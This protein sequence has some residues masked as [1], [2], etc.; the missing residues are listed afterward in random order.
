MAFQP[1]ENVECIC[2]MKKLMAAI[3]ELESNLLD[4]TGCDL[5]QAML[6]C[7]IADDSLSATEIASQIGVLPAQNSKLLAAAEDRGWV[8]RR[9]GHDDKRK[10]YFNLTEEGRRQLEKVKA[11]NIDVPDLIRPILDSSEDKRRE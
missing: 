6:L 7:V 11:L 10:I 5:N 2:T 3:R 4:S 9:L 1:M 8:M